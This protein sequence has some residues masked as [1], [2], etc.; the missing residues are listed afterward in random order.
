MS[1]N[2]TLPKIPVHP[3]TNFRVWVIPIHGALI[4]GIHAGTAFDA[5]LDLKMHF[6]VFVHGVAIGRADPNGTL[7]WAAAI[8][9]IGIY[10]NMRF[11]FA[12]ALVAVS[13]QA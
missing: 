1:T 6:L 11:N 9:D 12:A 4:A 7:M 8:A 3:A 5:V 13:H 10:H 2:A